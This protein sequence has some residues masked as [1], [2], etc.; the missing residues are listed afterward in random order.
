MVCPKLEKQTNRQ[1]PYRVINTKIGKMAQA[2]DRRGS[3]LCVHPGGF[4]VEVIGMSLPEGQERTRGRGQKPDRGG[5]GV[6]E[7][8]GSHTVGWSDAELRGRVRR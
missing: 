3:Q 4:L 2:T 6:G 5:R 7:S 1:C 8:V